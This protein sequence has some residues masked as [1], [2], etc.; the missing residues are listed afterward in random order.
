M[1]QMRTIEYQVPG[2]VDGV[3]PAPPVSFDPESPL[4]KAP[5]PDGVVR[6]TADEITQLTGGNLGLFD[7]DFGVGGTF[8]DRFLHMIEVRTGGAGAAA[9]ISV[10][11]ARDPNLA[12]MEEILAPAAEADFYRDTCVFVPQGAAL[13]LAG[14]NAVPGQPVVI[15]INVVAWGSMED[16][17][18]L[19]EQCCCETA[20]GGNGGE[21]CC[22]PAVITSGGPGGLPQD[23]AAVL[24]LPAGTCGLNEP[25]TAEVFN[26]PGSPS[27]TVPTVNSVTVTTGTPPDPNTVDISMDTTLSDGSYL[28]VLTN[29][30]G[31]CAIV[32]FSVQAA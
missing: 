28:L 8:A 29:A 7:P 24:S 26:D 16:Y 15:R 6:F 27:G 1:L 10:V 2:L 18:H 14:F 32:R 3:T 31:C 19:L 21:P 20:T 23:P 11:D 13:G 9:T 5:E 12:G 30:C 4:Y 22:P 17:A 25:L